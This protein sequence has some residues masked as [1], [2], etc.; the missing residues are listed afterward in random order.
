M[1]PTLSL[2]AAIDGL[3]EGIAV[4]DR[5]LRVLSANQAWL[6]APRPRD[7]RDLPQPG[8]SYMQLWQGDRS[9]PIRWFE[10]SVTRV[11]LAR[12]F[13]LLVVHR[14]VTAVE[15]GARALHVLS[16][17]LLRAQEAERRRIARELHDQTA[18]NLTAIT[19]SLSRIELA[20]PAGDKSMCSLLTETRELA[21]R[22]VTQIRTLSYLLHPP[23]LDDEGLV[24]A[25]RWYIS[26]F[27]KRSGIRT[28]LRVSSEF[29]RLPRDVELALFVVVQGCLT[30]VYNH[31]GSGRA[32]IRLRRWPQAVTVEVSNESRRLT[33]EQR[34]ALQQ[35][36]GLGI[37]SIRE[38]LHVVGGTLDIHPRGKGVTATA[39]VPLPARYRPYAHPHR[40]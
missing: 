32:S 15:R 25:L 17:R 34:K 13:N 18:Q 33:I 38:R 2:Q 4:L 11:G 5:D 35:S 27:V 28:G 14:D 8:E 22:C 3:P 30:N 6:G 23:L 12:S 7:G 16:R 31:S 1:G 26:G 19:L 21:Q 29:G 10:L 39:T 9:R 40:R 20:S 36:A 24:S 37:R